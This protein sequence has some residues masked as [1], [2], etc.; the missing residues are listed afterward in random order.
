MSA[1]PK[2]R[3]GGRRDI[4]PIEKTCPHCGKDYSDTS[5][6]HNRTSCEAEECLRASRR[7]YQKAW[8]DRTTGTARAT[9]RGRP[10]TAATQRFNAFD[11]DG[12]VIP[13][14]PEVNRKP[15]ESLDTAAAEAAVAANPM[16]KRC[17]KCTR[18]FFGTSKFCGG[19]ICN[20]AIEERGTSRR[21][22]G[23]QLRNG[24]PILRVA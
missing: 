11:F 4:E 17:P 15:A 22:D 13:T 23:P 18:A 24:Q 16:N 12:G 19:A 20:R 9:R 21:W 8:W 14:S 7:A 6:R 10:K 3:R 1:S 5:P 2:T